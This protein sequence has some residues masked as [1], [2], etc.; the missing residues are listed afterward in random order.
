MFSK[1]I[2]IFRFNSSNIFS[3]PLL[4]KYFAKFDASN[5]FPLISILLLF[6]IKNSLFF[7]NTSNDLKDEYFF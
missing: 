3:L 4:L 7:V 5:F 6:V 2:S 1:S